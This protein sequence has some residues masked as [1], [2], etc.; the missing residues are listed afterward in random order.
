[1]W[2]P[3]GSVGFRVYP[4]ANLGAPSYACRNIW[5]H[6]EPGDMFPILSEGLL[7]PR[8]ADEAM[9]VEVLRSPKMP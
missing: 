7:C 8:R 4:F 5:T 9:K 2:Y 3:A 1:M 6:L